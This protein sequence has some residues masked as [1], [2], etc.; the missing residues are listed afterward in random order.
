MRATYKIPGSATRTELRAF[1]RVEFERNRGVTDLGNVRYLVG[2]G[3]A[4]FE[5]VERGVVGY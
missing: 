5:R 1:A 2:I 4:E 3:K